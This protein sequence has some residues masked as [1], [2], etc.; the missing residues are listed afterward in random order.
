[1][2]KCFLAAFAKK[3]KPVDALENFGFWLDKQIEFH[4]NSITLDFGGGRLTGA[5]D[6]METKQGSKKELTT[7]VLVWVFCQG[8]HE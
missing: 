2:I 7:G 8:L 5:F 1:M 3:S 6:K 4:C